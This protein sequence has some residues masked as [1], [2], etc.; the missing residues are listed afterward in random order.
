MLYFVFILFVFLFLTVLWNQHLVRREGVV[1]SL[2]TLSY[3]G[4]RS[5]SVELPRDVDF[6]SFW[7]I[8]TTPDYKTILMIKCSQ[9]SR[10]YPKHLRETPT[11]PAAWRLTMK[12]FKNKSIRRSLQP[13]RLVFLSTAV[14]IL[15]APHRGLWGI[16]E[17]LAKPS[18]SKGFWNDRRSF[19]VLHWNHLILL[20]WKRLKDVGKAL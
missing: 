13:L 3:D 7:T 18:G 1:G 9:V 11:W 14:F 17:M 8:M 2:W 12:L 4:G 20:W 15:C 6:N 16:S 10:G 19:K 5:G